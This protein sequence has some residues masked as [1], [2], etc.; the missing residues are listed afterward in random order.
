MPKRKES[1]PANGGET[2]YAQMMIGSI[3]YEILEVPIVGKTSLIMNRFGPKAREMIR[4]IEAGKKLPKM[5]RDPMAEFREAFYRLPENA[6]DPDHRNWTIGFPLLAFKAATVGAARFY[7]RAVSMVGLKQFMWFIPEHYDVEDGVPLA[8][9]EVP[10]IPEF[11]REDPVRVRNG[12]TTLRYRPEFPEWRTVL[13]I[14]YV[15]S[16]I[17]ATDLLS[18]IDAGGANVGVGEW[19]PE[20]GSGGNSGINGTYQVD[21][22]RELIRREVSNVPY[23]IV[24]RAAIPATA[25]EGPAVEVS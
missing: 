2:E 5:P 6:D 23:N 17:R 11:P 24:E 10:E 18:L 16:A 20:K 22:E 14:R 9:L 21:H 25:F 7:G 13:K 3:P 1:A 15:K 4:A 19:R 12:G 8:K